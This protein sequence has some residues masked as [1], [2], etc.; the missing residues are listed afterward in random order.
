MAR[1]AS[2]LV[3]MVTLCLTVEAGAAE[4]GIKRLS[5][6]LFQVEGGTGDQAWHIQYGDR[7]GG[8]FKITTLGGPGSTA[9]FSHGNWLCT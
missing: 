7:A 4:I 6:T 2:L 8:F 1:T 5:R 3:A 9:Y